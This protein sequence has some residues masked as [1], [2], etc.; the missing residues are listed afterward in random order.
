MK[1]STVL[2]DCER[3]KYP[4]TGLYEYCSQLSNAL[5]ADPQPAIGYTFYVPEKENGFLGK[6]RSYVFQKSSHKF[7]GLPT[8]NINLWHGT[9]QGSN[10]YPKSKRVKKML[11]IHDLNFLYDERKSPAKKK[12]YT[13]RL[14]DKIDR[15]DQLTAISH[16]TLECVQQHL[17]LR[18]IPVE[19]IYNGCS[20]DLAAHP[21]VKP[22]FVTD[23]PYLF[24][25]GTIALKKNFHVLPALLAGNE[26]KLIIAGIQQDP[27]YVETILA[28]AAKHGVTDRVIIPGP[29]T[30]GEKWWL[31]EHALAFVFP[32][33]S[34]GFGIP[35]VEAMHFGIPVL[36]STHTCL[37]ETGA[38]AAYY[39]NSFDAGDM[40]QVLRKS[41][42]HYAAHPEQKKRITSRAAFFNWKKSA[43]EYSRLYKS[44]LNNP[45]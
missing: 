32:S 1:D 8:R 4:F 6:D 13:K 41:L 23:A 12:N 11:T 2:I 7:F 39:F 24:S 33:I 5:I 43:G 38:D 27:A 20:I 15:S 40:Q 34:E 37:P 30:Q 42:Q 45:G 21:P 26:Y 36:L 19:V 28:E 16:F 44:L 31:L 3:M 14:Q 22:A 29:V 9:F 18:N 17:S 35:V 25:I 10:Y